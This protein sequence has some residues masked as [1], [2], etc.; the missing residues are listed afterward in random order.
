MIRDKAYDDGH[1]TPQQRSELDGFGTLDMPRVIDAYKA[2]PLA[3]IW[4]TP[5]YL[6]NGSVPTIY[7]LLSP[8]VSRPGTF[9]VGVRAFDTAHLGLA[10]RDGYPIFDTSLPGNHNTGHEFSPAYN[11]A[12]RALSPPGVIGPL[13]SESEKL[14]IIEYLKIRDDDRDGK[15][16]PSV[17]HEQQCVV[18]P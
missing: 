14:A 17:P 8:V 1:Y 16:T 7:D 4:A 2:R 12:N 11:A 18:T 3:G 13:L 9:P 6:H 5:P 10:R 15:K